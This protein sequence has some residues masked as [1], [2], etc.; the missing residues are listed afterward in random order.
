MCI[1]IDANQAGELARANKP[2]IQLVLK[3]IESGG[4][5]VS[6]GHLETELIEHSEM[7]NLLTQLSRSGQLRRIARERIV[8]RAALIA[9]ACKSNDPHVVALA[10]EAGT[11][12]IVT[13]DKNL[14]SDLKNLELVGRR[15]RILKENS[16]QPNRTRHIPPLLQSANCT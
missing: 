6:G 12:V 9:A 13:Q 8:D 1:I 11:N 4:A 3:W 10:I 15:R 2:Y 5:I 14:I 16:A 7:A